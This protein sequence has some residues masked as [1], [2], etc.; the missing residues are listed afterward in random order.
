MSSSESVLRWLQKRQAGTG[1]DRD[2]YVDPALF[3]LELE[4]IFYREWIFAAHTA[5]LPTTCSYLTIQIGAYPIVMVR[6]GDGTINAFI[7]SCRHRGARLCPQ[8]RGVAP[9]LV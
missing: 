7:N 5:E 9:K 4:H 2:F 1:L 8:E 6:A 3:A